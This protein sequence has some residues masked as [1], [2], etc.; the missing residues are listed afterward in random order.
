M[1]EIEIGN[2]VSALGLKKGEEKPHTLSFPGCGKVE[3]IWTPLDF[4]KV[5]GRVSEVTWLTCFSPEGEQA[6]S[7]CSWC[8]SSNACRR[9][10]GEVICRGCSMYCACAIIHFL[11]QRQFETRDVPNLGPRTEVGL[12]C[13]LEEE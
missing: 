12:S 5:D 4:G 1:G 7:S 3:F 9:R 11:A 13:E 2:I 8:S 6:K 10:S